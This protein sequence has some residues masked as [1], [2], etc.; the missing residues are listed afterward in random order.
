[1]QF[2]VYPQ[3]ITR[4]AEPDVLSRSTSVYQVKAHFFETLRQLGPLRVLDPSA[5]TDELASVFARPDSVLAYVHAEKDTPLALRL[6]HVA[7]RSLWHSLGG[8]MLPDPLAMLLSRTPDRVSLVM[9]DVQRERLER[10]LGTAVSQ[11]A[12]LPF[13]LD[14]EFWRPPTAAERADARARH[15]IEGDTRHLVHAG[16]FLVTKGLCQWLRALSLHPLPDSV[17][18]CAGDFEPTFPIQALATDHHGFPSYFTDRRPGVPAGTRW[19]PPLGPDAL[20][21]L[22]WSADA[23]VCPSW[24]EDENYNITVRQAALCGVAPVVADFGG[25][26]ALARQLP[27]GGV[28][29]YPTP[30]GVRFSL[31]ELRSHIDA[32]LAPRADSAPWLDAVRAE[33]DGRASADA[34]RAAVVR[35]LR[36]PLEAPAIDAKPNAAFRAIFEHGDAA[37]VRALTAPNRAAPPG[38]FAPGTGPYAPQFPCNEFFAAV[39]GIYTTERETPE[40]RAGTAYRGFFPCR[41]AEAGGAVVEDGYPGPRIWP[42][43]AERMAQLADCRVVAHIAP[44]DVRLVPRSATQCDALRDLVAAGFF[45]PDGA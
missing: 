31:R 7:R 43:D 37:L 18:T 24:H 28:A 6:Q 35:L 20:R 2:F 30:V 19:I 8:L 10:A 5:N 15:G 38:L 41:L 36:R 34:L 13:P 33:C 3:D 39:Q 42:L 16:R 32:A 4:A 12:V 11:L 22:F 9:T 23:C 45:V 25:L 14:T 44:N 17:V 40:V 29:T 26:A 27:W 21:S 1:M